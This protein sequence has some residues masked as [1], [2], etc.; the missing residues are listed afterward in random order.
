LFGAGPESKVAMGAISSFFPVAISVAAGVRGV[1]AVLVR[2][3][4]SF[5]ASALQMAL[6]IYLPA[7]RA[8]MLNGLRLGFGVAAIGVL[9]AETKLSKA[10]IG[11]LIMDAY[12][13]FDM[14][15][16]YALLILVVV[17]IA[18]LNAALARLNN[19]QD[20]GH[21]IGRK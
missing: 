9:L 6:K 19:R 18:G 13:L 12:R 10:G 3:G 11:F 16:M 2:V 4:R 15:L 14:P 7:V 8:A 21:N 17:L 20:T 5:R 1:D